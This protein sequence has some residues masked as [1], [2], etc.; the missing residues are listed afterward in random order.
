MSPLLRYTGGGGGG[1]GGGDVSIVKVHYVFGGEGRGGSFLVCDKLFCSRIAGYVYNICVF[2]YVCLCVRVLY[3]Y[4][5]YVFV[6]CV[7]CMCLYTCA[8]IIYLH[9]LV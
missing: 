6:V 2:V 7:Q 4:I 1:G 3:M 8:C 9:V 5:V